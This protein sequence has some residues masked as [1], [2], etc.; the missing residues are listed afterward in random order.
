MTSNSTQCWAEPFGWASQQFGVSLLGPC[1][2]LGY[3]FG[4]ATN[5]S[6]FLQPHDPNGE[7]PP[8]IVGLLSPTSRGLAKTSGSFDIILNPELHLD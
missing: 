5:S 3:N 6:S 4:E 8:H 1:G 7:N 2:C